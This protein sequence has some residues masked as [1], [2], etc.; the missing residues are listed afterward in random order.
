M[1]GHVVSVKECGEIIVN[2]PV[3]AA[4][5]P[6]SRQLSGGYPPQHGGIT[7]AAA[8]GNKAYGD[9]LRVPR[10]VLVWQDNSSL[11]SIRKNQH[12]LFNR[13]GK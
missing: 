5:Q 2:Y 13:K 7:Y 9:I 3:M 6:E 12:R 11:I 4:G 1:C 10:F 8:P